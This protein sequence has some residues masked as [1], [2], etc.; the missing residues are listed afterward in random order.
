M[1]SPESLSNESVELDAGFEQ[2]R[3]LELVVESM[4]DGVIVVDAD[5]MFK[6]FNAA[7]RQIIGQGPSDSPV[8]DWAKVYGIYQPYRSS[9]GAPRHH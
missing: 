5:G 2:A 6:L 4:G 8:K 9:C 3:A 1:L 7:A